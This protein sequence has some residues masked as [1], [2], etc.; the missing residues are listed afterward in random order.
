MFLSVGDVRVYYERE[1]EGMSVL[2]L[3]GWGGNAMSVKPIANLLKE[4]FSVI[5]LDLP[6]FGRT[7]MP[8][9]WGVE[10]YG[11][12]IKEFLGKLGIERTEIVTHSFSGR[13]GIFLA[14]NFP[15]IVNRLVLIDSAGIRRR[16]PIY[17]TRLFV[18]KVLG[19][20]PGAKYVFHNLMGSRDWREAGEMRETLV[21]VVNWDAKPYLSK[22]SQ[23]TLLIWG[24]N[25]KET[26]LSS[27]KIMEREIENAHLVILKGA[28]HFSY[29]DNFTEFSKALLTFLQ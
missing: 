4:R 17:W 1:G 11:L 20:I 23:R 13:I 3:H 14:A 25:D 19:R 2:L 5:S 24:E 15:K 10:D 28:G 22:I 21:K 12:F 27:A 29:L 26:P 6:G 8:S 9:A 18:S 7:D 16:P